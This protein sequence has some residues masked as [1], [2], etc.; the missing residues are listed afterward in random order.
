MWEFLLYIL[1]VGAPVYPSA[2]YIFRKNA[3][4]VWVQI[5]KLVSPNSG[6]WDSFGKYIGF[7]GDTI[8]VSS[9]Y[10]LLKPFA[11][12]ICLADLHTH[13][14]LKVGAPGE[15]GKAYLYIREGDEASG[16]W[17]STANIVIT[18]PESFDGF[19]NSDI[20]EDTLVR[21]ISSDILTLQRFSLFLI[22]FRWL[23]VTTTDW[24]MS[25]SAPMACGTRLIL[26][27]FGALL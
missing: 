5:K 16:N 11:L 14:I 8:V 10:Y 26:I 21:Y 6:T 18:N 12:W 2:V 3:S 7:Y 1:T 19:G 17:P 20:Y 4:N 22:T 27:D 9:Q 25:T 24:W 23:V 15:R 13:F